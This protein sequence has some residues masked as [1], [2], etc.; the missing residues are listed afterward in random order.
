MKGDGR[1]KG[2]GFPTANIIPDYPDKIIPGIGSYAATVEF[3]DGSVYSGMLNIGNN[4]TFNCNKVTIEMNIFDFNKD[5]YDEIVT[6][7]FYQKIR[8]V[9]KFDSPQSLVGQLKQDEQ[10]VREFFKDVRP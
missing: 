3:K 10:N 9:V 6:V 1:G 4:P 8:D 5:I 7:E 2:L